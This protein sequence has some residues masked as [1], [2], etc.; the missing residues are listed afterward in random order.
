MYIITRKV[1]Y[2]T[3]CRFHVDLLEKK[4]FQRNQ[5]FKLFKDC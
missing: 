3:A 5:I 4:N 2:T 1:Y